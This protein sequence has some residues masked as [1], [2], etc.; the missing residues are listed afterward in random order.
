MIRWA[1]II[2]TAL[3]LVLALS[4][5]GGSSKYAGLSKQEARDDA[6]MALD[7]NA[8]RA[9]LSAED[10]DW[11]K[12]HGV[13]FFEQRKG[14]NRFGDK[15]WVVIYMDKDGQA[16]CMTVWARSADEYGW[17]GDTC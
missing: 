1:L 12:T 16:F 13:R 7:K 10:P 2:I 9:G 14:K 3:A 5:C 17:Q 11:R 4:A 8:K 6:E 15:A